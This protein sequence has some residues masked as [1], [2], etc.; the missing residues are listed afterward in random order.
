MIR[1][2]I[3]ASFANISFDQ[4]SYR[5]YSVKVGMTAL[6]KSETG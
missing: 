2:D 4:P 3:P 1:E 6:F 5:R